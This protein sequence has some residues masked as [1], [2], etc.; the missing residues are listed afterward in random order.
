MAPK[1]RSKNGKNSLEVDKQ[2]HVKESSEPEREVDVQKSEH[3]SEGSAQPIEPQGA[4]PS[5]EIVTAG[6]ETTKRKSRAKRGV[7]AM[8]KVVVKKAQGKKFKVSSS[9]LGTPMSGKQSCQKVQVES[10]EIK[11]KLAP[12]AKELLEELDCVA[13]DPTP[14]ETKAT[15]SAYMSYLHNVMREKK[16]LDYF[17]FFDPSA[18]FTLN[19][20]FED[21]VVRRLKEGNP[22]RVFFMPHHQNVHW[23]LIVLWEH[24]IY[25]LNPPP[26][27]P[28][29]PALEDALKRALK[30]FNSQRGNRTPKVQNLAGS[31]KQPG[32]HEFGYVFMRYMRDIILDEDMYSFSTKWLLKTRTSYK[33]EELEEVRHKTLKH[34]EK[35]M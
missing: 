26:H 23:I 5:E 34:I 2:L 35:L 27:P 32:S 31:P 30:T 21:L 4:Q 11:S 28:R 13:V 9:N 10:P 24:D 25:T 14:P 22:N 16:L 18:T 29:N 6:T 1:K 19:A 12:A 7:C 3:E 8:H 33:I 17:G 20:N 15:I